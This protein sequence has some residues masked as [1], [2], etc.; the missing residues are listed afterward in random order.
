MLLATATMFSADAQRVRVRIDFPSH[1][2]VRPSAPAP[3][4]GAVWIGPE[5]SWQ[6]GRYVAVPGYWS[7][8]VRYR[9]VWVNGY[10]DRGRRGYVWVPGHWR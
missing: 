9:A 7:R 6:R 3:F 10:W 2:M 4:R 1:V 5:W 8:P